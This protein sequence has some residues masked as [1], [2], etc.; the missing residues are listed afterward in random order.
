MN[1]SA[2]KHLLWL[3]C[4]DKNHNFHSNFY[5]LFCSVAFSQPPMEYLCSSLQD[6]GKAWFFLPET[7]KHNSPT[8][9]N[10][11]LEVSLGKGQSIPEIFP[12]HLV[13][14]DL[15]ALHFFWNR[16]VLKQWTKRKSSRLSWDTG[17]NSTE[18]PL[19]EHGVAVMSSFSKNHI[20][21][22]TKFNCKKV[23][24]SFSLPESAG[25]FINA[26]SSL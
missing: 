3:Y 10:S 2:P 4:P 1:C 16:E 13:H 8:G 17:H 11:Q 14:I 6:N 23:A 9:H 24:S 12:S 18:S 20:K 22:K 5:Y 7:G 21:L 25:Q 19:K 15:W 26:P